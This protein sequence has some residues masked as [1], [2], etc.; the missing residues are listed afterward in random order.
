MGTL[1]IANG[2][3]ERPYNYKLIGKGGSTPSFNP[4][5]LTD[6]RNWWAVS[7]VSQTDGT[8]V[9]LVQDQTAGQNL[10]AGN[11]TPSWDAG[12]TALNFDD[13]NDEYMFADVSAVNLTPPYSVNM[14]VQLTDVAANTDAIWSNELV[15]GTGDLSLRGR[16]GGQYG[17]RLYHNNAISS[18]TIT[19]GL[20]TW[21]MVTV[22]ILISGWSIY[23]NGALS[24]SGTEAGLDI[25]TF[26][27]GEDT[28]TPVTGVTSPMRVGDIVTTTSDISANGTDLAD[29]YTY[30]S[31]IY[32]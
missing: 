6:I 27:V 22:N 8:D 29:L 14:M 18:G 32:S 11:T 24:D 31:A 13:T 23:L 21:N 20:N 30:M 17:V 12:S 4:S 2:R 28:T 3:F 9:T 10:N 15:Y 7:L 19:L 5:Q 16:G 26:L 25:N 1:D